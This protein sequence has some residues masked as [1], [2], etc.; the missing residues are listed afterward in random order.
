MTLTHVDMQVDD[1]VLL[2]RKSG[3]EKRKNQVEMKWIFGC[4]IGDLFGEL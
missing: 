3:E 4:S 2:H 1:Q